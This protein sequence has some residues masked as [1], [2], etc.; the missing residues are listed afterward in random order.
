MLH[1]ES[2]LWD[3][4]LT[5][6]EDG[7]R[8]DGLEQRNDEHGGGQKRQKVEPQRHQGSVSACLQ[9]GAGE[10]P[11][12]PLPALPKGCRP[13]SWTAQ[14]IAVMQ[15]AAETWC[16]AIKAVSSAARWGYSLPASIRRCSRCRASQL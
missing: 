13:E 15:A 6:P 4:V 1:V 2:K 14:A 11:A 16:A 8:L 10:S 3:A 7:R 12:R 9:A 5:A